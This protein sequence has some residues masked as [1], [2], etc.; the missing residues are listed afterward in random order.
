M[1]SKIVAETLVVQVIANT[2]MGFDPTDDCS[3]PSISGVLLSSYTY[4]CNWIVSVSSA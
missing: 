2:E 3:V 4:Y 1:M